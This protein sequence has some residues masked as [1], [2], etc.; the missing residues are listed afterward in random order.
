MAANLKAVEKAPFFASPAQIG[1]QHTLGGLRTKGSSAQ[2]LDRH[3]NP[4]PRLYAAGEA[5]G[6][7]HGDNRIGG[8]GTAAAVVFGRLSGQKAAAEKPWA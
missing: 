4:I 7:T 8:N 5:S 1:V 2:V 6:G 3:G